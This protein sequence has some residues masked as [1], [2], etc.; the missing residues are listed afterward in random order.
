MD[1]SPY[2]AQAIQSMS[3]TPA[4]PS[5]GG[6]AISPDQARAFRAKADAFHAANP[7]GSFVGHQLMQAGRN[8]MNLPGQVGQGL[9]GL[10]QRL[11]GMGGSQPFQAVGAVPQLQ[12]PVQPNGPMVAPPGY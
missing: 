8:V 3:Q 11:P 4:A 6:F 9:Y 7:N 2:L 5:G 1:S 10:A 12:A